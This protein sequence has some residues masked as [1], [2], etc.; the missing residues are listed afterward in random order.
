MERSN[1]QRREVVSDG[2]GGADSGPPSLRRKAVLERSMEVRAAESDVKRLR[3]GKVALMRELVRANKDVHW[4]KLGVSREG[5]SVSDKDVAS[6]EG[7]IRTSY[8]QL[9]EKREEVW[10][11]KEAERLAVRKLRAA[12][13]AQRAGEHAV[14][15]K[16]CERA[17]DEMREEI[18]MHRSALKDEVEEEVGWKHGCQTS[19][20]V[21]AERVRCLETMRCEYGVD[22]EE[23]S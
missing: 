23:G 8:F 16:K 10:Q 7:D 19:P 1:M 12:E 15:I 3:E 14:E 17:I 13:A 18:T 6:A 11:A 4:T 20:E 22:V 2:Q 5:V 9:H 21:R